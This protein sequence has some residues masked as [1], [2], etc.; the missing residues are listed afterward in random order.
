MRD[1][2]AQ[3]RVCHIVK[4][5]HIDSVSGHKIVKQHIERGAHD[6]HQKGKT[7]HNEYLKQILNQAQ[8]AALAVFANNRW[9]LTQG[10]DCFAHDFVAVS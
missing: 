2:A 8:G 7:G 4:F 1:S 5:F 10:V 9:C 3:L 6:K